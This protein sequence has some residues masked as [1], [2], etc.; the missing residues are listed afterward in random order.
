MAIGEGKEKF[1]SGKSF[2]KLA[3]RMLSLLLEDEPSCSLQA[4][5]PEAIFI[6]GGEMHPEKSKRNLSYQEIGALKVEMENE[7]SQVLLNNLN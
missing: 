4:G 3:N 2:L 6:G 5:K 1:A 7:I